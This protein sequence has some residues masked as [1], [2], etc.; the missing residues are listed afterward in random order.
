MAFHRVGDD[1]SLELWD[2]VSAVTTAAVSPVVTL[3]TPNH[4]FEELQL[5][6]TS[7]L[8]A[9]PKNNFGD[10]DVS[11]YAVFKEFCFVEMYYYFCSINRRVNWLGSQ[12]HF[13]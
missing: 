1:S 10:I 5:C 7:G 13:F 9:I 3:L 8:L 6:E 11:V 4:N 2:P 12:A